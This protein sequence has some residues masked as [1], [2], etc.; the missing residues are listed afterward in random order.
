MEIYFVE[1]TDKRDGS[2]FTSNKEE[3][4]I[5]FI[6]NTEKKY[7]LGFLF[8]KLLVKSTGVNSFKVQQSCGFI[9]LKMLK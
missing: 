4:F 7:H 6:E 3:L 5:Y 1:T 8:L 9:S 2:E